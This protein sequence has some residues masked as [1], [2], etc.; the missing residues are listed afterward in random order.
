[1][2]G[3]TNGTGC[4]KGFEKQEIDGDVELQ[5]FTSVEGV[6]GNCRGIE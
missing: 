5:G 4:T 2:Y 3:R 6:H 1:V